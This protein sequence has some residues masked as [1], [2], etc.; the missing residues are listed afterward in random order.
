MIKGIYTAAAGLATAT[1]R[2]GVVSNNIANVST[3]GYKQDRLPDEVGNALDLMKFAVDD[4][5]RAVGTITLGPKIGLSQL[6]LA[7]G[8]MQQTANPLD[9]AIAGSGFFAVQAPD[10]TTR[11]T[12]DGGFHADVDGSLRARDGS[13]V[14]DTTGQPINLPLGAD[15]AVAADGTVLA[16][17]NTL[18]QIQM[19]DF[20]PGDTLTKVGNGM[21]TVQNG[22]QPLP[23]TGVQ[24]YQGY[25]EGSNTDMTESM[26]S[27]MNLVRAYESN[28]K[29]L[30][31]TDATLKQAVNDVGKA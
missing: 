18:A 23:T 12:R 31:M 10:G 9:L 1:L 29:L 11:Y 4:Q 2:L 3:P 28:Q 21:F 17:G 15:V 14:L 8:P 22:V 24:L 6:D 7:A 5:G 20:A 16:G 26:V 13:S 27:T 19:V 25:L 30:Q